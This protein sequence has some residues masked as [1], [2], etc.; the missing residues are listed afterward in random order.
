MRAP[1]TGMRAHEMFGLGITQGWMIQDGKAVSKQGGEKDGNIDFA[2]DNFNVNAVALQVVRNDDGEAKPGDAALGDREQVDF[3]GKRLVTDVDGEGSK[4]EPAKPSELTPE[5]KGARRGLKRRLK[6]T[7]PT[8]PHSMRTLL[9]PVKTIR[10]IL[11]FWT[12]L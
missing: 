4:S 11:P 1:G 9:L 2:V 6:R 7:I 8:S 3:A 10:S 5:E 12:L